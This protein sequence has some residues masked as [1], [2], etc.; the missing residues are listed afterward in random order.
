MVREQFTNT[1]PK[2]VPVLF[3]ERSPKD[4]KEL[5]KLAEQYLNAHVKKLSTKAPVT[6]QDVKTSSGRLL[7]YYC[8]VTSTYL[9][10]LNFDYFYFY[11][12]SSIRK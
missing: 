12:R 2:D 9:S 4:L 8:L 11:L 6:K 3:K 7:K 1:C 5:A 10:D